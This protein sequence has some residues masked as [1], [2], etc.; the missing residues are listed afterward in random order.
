MS[1]QGS[2]IWCDLHPLTQA[3]SFHPY[4][5]VLQTHKMGKL[6]SVVVGHKPVGVGHGFLL[7]LTLNLLEDIINANKTCLFPIQAGVF[8]VCSFRTAVV[9]AEFLS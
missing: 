5:V 7:K 3:N 8:S 6:Y 2:H 9:T 1:E 4:V